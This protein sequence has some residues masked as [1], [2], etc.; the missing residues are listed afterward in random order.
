MNILE[1]LCDQL[2][3]TCG[4]CKANQ[5]FL[6]RGFDAWTRTTAINKRK[7]MTGW[8]FHSSQSLFVPQQTT[9]VNAAAPWTLIVWFSHSFRFLSTWAIETEN[10]RNCISF[11]LWTVVC[12]LCRLLCAINNLFRCDVS[13]CESYIFT[14]I[15]VILNIIITI[16]MNDFIPAFNHRFI[17]FVRLMVTFCVCF[18]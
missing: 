3:T 15:S 2:L 4:V 7:I 12:R 13:T 11:C 5:L 9:V 1:S 18:L 14:Y 6:C 10:T 17:C 8:N 16:F